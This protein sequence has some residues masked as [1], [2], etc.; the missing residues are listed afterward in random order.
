MFLTVA[1]ADTLFEPWIVLMAVR[2]RSALEDALNS[3][4]EATSTILERY[5]VPRPEKI[6]HIQYKNM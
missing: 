6:E 5:D 1:D 2:F 3:G 4:A